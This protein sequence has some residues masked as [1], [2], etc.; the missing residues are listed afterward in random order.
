[1]QCHACQT[2]EALGTVT[3]HVCSEECAQQIGARIKPGSKETLAPGLWRQDPAPNKWNRADPWL[4]SMYNEAKKIPSSQ[5]KNGK[6]L[7]YYNMSYKGEMWTIVRDGDVWYVAKLKSNELDNSDALARATKHRLWE[8]PR[9]VQ[10]PPHGGAS[11]R[12]LTA[13]PR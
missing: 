9:P 6:P 5:I 4:V 11:V 1:M 12:L 3:L 7:L 2:N 13:G 8:Q 10:P